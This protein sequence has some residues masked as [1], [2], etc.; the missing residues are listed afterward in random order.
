MC[1]NAEHYRPREQ[2]LGGDL[3]NA[4][5]PPATGRKRNA[6]GLEASC[7]QVI[8]GE[9]CPASATRQPL[10]PPKAQDRYRTVGPEW[11]AAEAP[12]YALRGILDQC[13]TVRATLALNPIEIDGVAVEVHHDDGSHTVA[14][15]RLE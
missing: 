5:Q 8:V 1:W 14:E 15:S 4:G 11:L 3:G 6:G 2:P 9:G 10:S 7:S 12:S 13:G